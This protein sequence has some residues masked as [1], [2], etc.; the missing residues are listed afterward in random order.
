MFLS[1]FS[2]SAVAVFGVPTLLTAAGFT[3]GGV[4]AGSA[5]AGVQ[6]AAYGA[7]T[8]GVFS[9]LQSIGKLFK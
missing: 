5:A 6:S 1:S 3:A 4:V 8:G 2:G 9:V 7:A